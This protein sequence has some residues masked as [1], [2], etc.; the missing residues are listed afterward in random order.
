MLTRRNILLTAAALTAGLPATAHAVQTGARGLKFYNLHTGESLD[1]EYWR[2]GAYDSDALIA[3][4]HLLRDHRTSEAHQMDVRL[5]DLLHDLSLSLETRAPLLVISGY[6][7]PATNAALAAASSG[8]ARHSL[9][10]DGMAIDIAVEGIATE[11]IQQAAL[12]LGRGGVGY[13]PSPGFVH[14]DVGRV[15]RW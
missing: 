9:H 7:S 8:V 13:Y 3:I 4:N 2:N 5:L 6:R 14:V 12:E 1:A 10:M 15:R 11:T